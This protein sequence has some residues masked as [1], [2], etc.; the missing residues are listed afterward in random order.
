MT[1]SEFLD[2]IKSRGAKIFPAAPSSQIPLTN[3]ALQNI[4]AAMLPMVMINLYGEIGAINMGTGYI[5]GPNDI[6]RGA[7]Y[8]IPSIVKINQ[9]LTD[10]PTIQCKTIFGRNDLFWFAFDCFG[11]FYMLDSLTLRPLRK[12][13]DA[14]RAL[15]DCLMGGRI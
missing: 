2:A 8:P 7:E 13:D 3:T 15:T 10:T 9:E 6:E 12:Y 4:R 14:Y 1:Q 5:F 11:T